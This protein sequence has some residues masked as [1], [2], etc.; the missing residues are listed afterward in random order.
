MRHLLLLVLVWVSLVARF[1]AKAAVWVPHAIDGVRVYAHQ[2]ADSLAARIGV[3]AQRNIPRI[4]V[5]L[6]V[7]HPAPIDIYAYSD[8]AS[9][10]ADTS[11]D[12]LTLGVS[13]SPSGVIRLDATASD[14]G[15]ERTLA[16]ELTHSL[17]SQRLNGEIGDL[18][19]W[20][21]EGTAGQ[22]SEPLSRAELNRVAMMMHRDGALSL[23]DLDD[24]FR[25]HRML[26]VAYLQ[27][28]SMVAWLEEHYPGAM[29]AILQRMAEKQD[30]FD[31]ALF[32]TTGLTQDTWLRGWMKSVP[33]YLY[34]LML[35]NTP[36]I[37]APLALLLVLIVIMRLRKRQETEDMEL[38]EQESEGTNDDDTLERLSSE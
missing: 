8:T 31:R 37:Y 11:Q 22:L 7:T 14:F 23:G 21:N 16:H 20:V 1:P 6:G 28:R 33:D 19:T 30:S 36:V 4:A 17:I 10:L 2:G 35:L 26:D 9:F 3:L 38:E 18:P 32:L 29:K 24:A 25:T 34:W 27:S 13:Y 15:I 12:P 5:A